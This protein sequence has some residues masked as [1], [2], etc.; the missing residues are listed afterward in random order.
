ML[1][2]S[3]FASGSF[4]VQNPG[5]FSQNKVFRIFESLFLDSLPP[6]TRIKTAKISQFSIHRLKSDIEFPILSI[7]YFGVLP[8]E[9][10]LLL[11][12]FY[13]LC[14]ERHTG[15]GKKALHYIEQLAIS[16]ELYQVTLT[17][18]KYNTNTIEAYEKLGFKKTKSIDK[19]I[20]KGFIMDDYLM[21]KM[22]NSF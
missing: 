2:N 17:V 10:E 4:L 18:N 1:Q 11:S 21:V 19:D 5:K 6:I 8:K 7:G 13:I 9:S 14:S 12:K 3:K 20:G 16:K 22:L 15:Y